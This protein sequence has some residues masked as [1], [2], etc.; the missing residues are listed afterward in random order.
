RLV[1]C[2]NRLWQPRSRAGGLRGAEAAALLQP[3]LQNDE[4]V[5]CRIGGKAQRGASG[6]SLPP[7]VRGF[8]IGSERHGAETDPL[9]L[10][11]EGAAGKENPPVTT[12]FLSRRHDGRGIAVRPDA[13]ASAIRPAVSGLRESPCAL[14]VWRQECR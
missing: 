12:A 9:L 8:R 11:P 5:D 2:A 3:L 1:V 4:P 13:N 14:L 7:A 10:E 6:R